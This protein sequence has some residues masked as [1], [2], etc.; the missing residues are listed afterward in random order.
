MRGDCGKWVVVGRAGGEGWGG[1]E[2]ARAP[3]TKP[4]GSVLHKRHRTSFS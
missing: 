3:H 1:H 2:F 4:L